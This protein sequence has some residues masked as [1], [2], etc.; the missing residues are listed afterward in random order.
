MASIEYIAASAIAAFRDTGSAMARAMLVALGIR[1]ADVARER[2]PRVGEVV[3]A[4]RYAELME[5]FENA[6]S[7]M[8]GR[9]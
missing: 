9:A 3:S 8:D 2:G 7:P 5:C 6:E 4:S 1:P